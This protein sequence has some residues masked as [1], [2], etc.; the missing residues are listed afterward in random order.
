MVHANP[1]PFS[2]SFRG[3]SCRRKDH[4]QA[5]VHWVHLELSC[6]WR[7]EAATAVTTASAKPAADVPIGKSVTLSSEWEKMK[8]AQIVFELE[9]VRS[10][11]CDQ[12]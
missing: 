4:I 5:H 3:F 1:L 8:N 10:V 2:C 9:P 6:D 12:L 7:K 11:V